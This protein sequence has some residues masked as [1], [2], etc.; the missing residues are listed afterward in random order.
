[1]CWAILL[2]ME[3]SFTPQSLLPYIV[4]MDAGAGWFLTRFLGVIALVEN[5]VIFTVHF[6]ASG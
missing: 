3:S 2:L 6:F 4:A 5:G 1:M